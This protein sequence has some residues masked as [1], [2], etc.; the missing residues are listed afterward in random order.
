MG[1]IGNY[2]VVSHNE[3]GVGGASQFSYDAPEGKVILGLGWNGSPDDMHVTQAEVSEDGTSVTF[4][5]VLANNALASLQLIC[6]E[7]C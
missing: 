1:A 7:M 4:T 3:T 6:A 5:V 2:E